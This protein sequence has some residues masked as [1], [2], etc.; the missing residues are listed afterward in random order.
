MRLCRLRFGGLAWFAQKAREYVL[1]LSPSNLAKFEAAIG[2]YI[3]G[4]TKIRGGSNTARPTPS[5]AE[6][7]AKEQLRAVRE[8]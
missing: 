4:P 3:N 8:C 1:D 5:P 2:E 6:G 7:S